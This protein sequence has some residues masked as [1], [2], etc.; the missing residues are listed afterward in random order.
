MNI[1]AIENSTIDSSIALKSGE[2]LSQHSIFNQGTAEQFT[3]VIDT[4]LAQSSLTI[5]DIDRFVIGTGPGSFT[6]LRMALSI[7]K[8]FYLALGKPC[9]G[10]PSYAAIARQYCVEDKPCAIIFDAKKDKVYGAVYQRQ[11]DRIT[12]MIKENLFDLEDFLLNRC[13]SEYLFVGESFAFSE[14]IHEVYPYASILSIPT[15][16][17]ARGLIEEALS[18]EQEE[19]QSIPE[20]VELLYIH[21][22]TCTVRK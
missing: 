4:L 20:N 3:S 15:F 6:G 18:R 19:G 12:C 8:G 1:L 16:P 13:S 22:D 7:L 9:I 2:K 21:P 17:E 10:I 11:E 5:N 14:R